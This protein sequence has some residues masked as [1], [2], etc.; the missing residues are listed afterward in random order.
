[1]S[2]LIH[3]LVLVD[4][5]S[6]DEITE[7][8]EAAGARVI[9]V[10]R[11]RGLQLAAGADSARGDW[12]LFLHADTVLS[13]GWP[14]AVREHLD[15]GPDR[16]G[17]FALGFDSR[18]PAARLVAGWANLRAR[19]F[20]LPYGDQGMLISRALYRSTGGYPEIPLMEDVA[21]ARRL[22]R[23]RLVPLAARAVSSAER[24][25]R[26]GWLRRGWRNL[27]TQA[28]YFI[29]VP[30]EKLVRRYESD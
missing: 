15:R 24:Y 10:H 28:L 16:A 5:G 4:A 25:A 3:E 19:I 1:M 22:G 18:H 11:G 26:G 13:S 9:F 2:G 23:R 20:G 14:E 6:G 8:A 7:V 29:G 27:T 21:F 12:L 17:Y 30:P